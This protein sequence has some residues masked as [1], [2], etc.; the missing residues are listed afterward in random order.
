MLV[1]ADE[2]LLDLVSRSGGS[3]AVYR[4]YNVVG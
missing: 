1:A 3:L 2:G 4:G